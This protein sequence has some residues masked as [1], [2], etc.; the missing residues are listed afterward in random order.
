MSPIDHAHALAE[1]ADFR[2]FRPAMRFVLVDRARR[3]NAKRGANV[4]HVRSTPKPSSA[5]AR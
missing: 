3:R 1:R 2:P 5:I 4:A